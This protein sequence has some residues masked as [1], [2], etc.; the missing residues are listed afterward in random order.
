MNTEE[1]IESFRN[2]YE[3]LRAEI[4]KVIVGHHAIVEGTLIAVFGEAT[5]CWKGCRVWVKR[6]WCARWA[7]CWI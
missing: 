7:K 6:C 4:G 1:Q 3:A 2:A 5:F